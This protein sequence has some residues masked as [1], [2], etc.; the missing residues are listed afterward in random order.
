MNLYFKD[1]YFKTVFSRTFD[2]FLNDSF[3]EGWIISRLLFFIFSSKL[4]MIELTF[5][6][7][8]SIKYRES[9][10]QETWKMKRG[11]LKYILERIK[12]P[13]IKTTMNIK[14]SGIPIEFY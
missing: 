11:I 14:I 7:Y 8:S 2:P 13:S 4:K 12:G 10:K 5:R 3:N 6:I 9:Q 1:H